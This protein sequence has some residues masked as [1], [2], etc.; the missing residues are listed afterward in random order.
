MKYIK[1]FD[2]KE[3]AIGYSALTPLIF[4]INGFVFCAS[5]KKYGDTIIITEDNTDLIA[6]KDKTIEEL[7]NGWIICTFYN[8][9]IL[10]PTKI[11]G[12]NV[13]LIGTMIV[14]EQEIIP[15]NTYTFTT[16]GQHVIK[17][18]LKDVTKLPNSAFSGCITLRSIKLNS[19]IQSLGEMVFKNCNTLEEIY[20]YSKICPSFTKRTCHSY[21][22]TEDATVEGMNKNGILYFPKECDYSSML[23][24]IYKK[25][26][27][28]SSM[29]TY[30]TYTYNFG[31]FAWTGVEM[32]Y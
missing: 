15:N 26:S 20:F 6:I 17:L 24:P 2:N 8:T 13:D 30:P 21:Y 31:D 32:D 4:T 10:E 29:G 28:T 27:V 9:S 22:T 1:I 16:I 14:D 12:G 25:D 23:E 11:Y 7:N 18:L 19:N 3:E 5:K